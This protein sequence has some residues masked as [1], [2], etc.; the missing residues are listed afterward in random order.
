MAGLEVRNVRVLSLSLDYNQITWEIETT[1]EDVLDY[2]F[3]VLRSE[4]VSG[5]YTEVSKEMD[6]E[7]LFIDN[8]VKVGNIYRQYHYK[9]RLRNKASG[10]IKE[11]GPFQKAPEPTL[12]AQELRTH[13]NILMHEYIGRRAWLLPIRTFGMRCA[14]CWNPKLMKRRFSGCRT[15][16]DTSFVRGFYRPIE[17]WISIDPTTASQQPSNLGRLQQQST[18]ARM[19]HYPP[20]KPGDVIVEAENIR[21]TV[22][23][24]STTQEQRAVITQ[25]LQ[26]SRIESTDIEYLIPIDLGAP[27]QS[28][29]YTPSRN[30]TNP[31]TI[32][33][34]VPNQLDYDAI[35][36]L[37]PRPTR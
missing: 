28:M 10:A 20:V 26:L 11:F 25:E 37:F 27:M 34:V 9:I 29:L 32:E 1:A 19:A 21:W 4:S 15:C 6:D 33:G 36:S 23:P 5:P 22:R 17:I 24:V 13:L 31:T 8:C 12:I 2:T 14:A 18:T 16:F 7:F 35:F 3:Q 30:Y